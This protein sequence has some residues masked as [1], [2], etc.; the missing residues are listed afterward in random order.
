MSVNSWLIDN[1]Y[2]QVLTLAKLKGVYYGKEV[3]E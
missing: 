2:N 1:Y 3:V